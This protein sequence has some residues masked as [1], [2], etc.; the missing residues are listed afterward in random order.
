MCLLDFSVLLK[1]ADLSN[2]LAT[3]FASGTCRVL[4]SKGLKDA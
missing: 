4:K 2:N 3:I 1:S